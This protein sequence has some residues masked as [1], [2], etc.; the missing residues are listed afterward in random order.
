MLLVDYAIDTLI[1]VKNILFQVS[2]KPYVTFQNVKQNPRSQWFVDVV[3]FIKR[4][5]YALGSSV[6]KIL[7]SK[8]FKLQETIKNLRRYCW[9]F[10]RWTHQL[11]LK[12]LYSHHPLNRMWHLRMKNKIP[13]RNDSAMLVDI[14]WTRLPPAGG[15]LSVRPVASVHPRPW[16]IFA[17]VNTLP[18]HRKCAVN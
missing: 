12:I 10:M 17:P 7:H 1:I 9:S 4:T 14:S 2:V 13:G 18:E 8:Y 11:A 3:R 5:D 16:A 6:L 15:R